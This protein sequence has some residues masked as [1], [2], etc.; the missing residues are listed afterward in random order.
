MDEH[1]LINQINIIFEREKMLL[2]TSGKTWSINGEDNAKVIMYDHSDTLVNLFTGFLDENLKK[3]FLDTLL[4]TF[5][6]EC[7]E[8]KTEYFEEWDNSILSFSS[9]SALIF[10]TF[11]Q[12]G[13]KDEITS[14]IKI[15]IDDNNWKC[16]TLV[17]FLYDFLPI[18]KKHLDFKLIID[19]LHFVQS[20]N[21]FGSSSYDE[22]LKELQMQ[23]LDIGYDDVKEN[24]SRVNIEINKDKEKLIILFSNYGFNSKYEC[25]LNEIDE[26]INANNSTAF[27]GAVG[28]MRS[29]MEGII[30][31]LARKISVISNEEIPIYDEK[32]KPAG[33][34][35]KYLQNKLRLHENDHNLIGRYIDILHIEGGHSFTSSIEYFR[36][37][38]NIGIEIC[39][40]LLSKTRNLNLLKEQ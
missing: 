19:L 6:N 23:L 16:V 11:L 26:C 20:Q 33:R 7:E 3:K 22:L 34:N 24:I 12:L 29:F 10:Y 38:K 30:T 17:Y 28:N 40:F 14:I 18:K 1:T 35:R 25:L 13:F 5:I 37:A 2:N 4:D 15:R 36:L 8:V 39:L 21:N 31:D 9:V 32:M 27:S